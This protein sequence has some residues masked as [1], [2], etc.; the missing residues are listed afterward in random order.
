MRR[1]KSV[2]K[3]REPE[4]KAAS[5][6]RDPLGSWTQRCRL[7]ILALRRVKY[8]G[9]EGSLGYSIVP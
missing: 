8:H 6:R 9:F 3:H 7:G 5:D 1:E 4:N 2:S